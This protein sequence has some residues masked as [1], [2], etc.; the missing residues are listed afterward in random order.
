VL[1]GAALLLLAALAP[2]SLFRLLPFLEAGP[3]AT[4]R[5]QPT[6]ASPRRRT[7]RRT[8]QRRTACRRGRIPRH[9]TGRRHRRGG[10]H[11]RWRRWIG[12]VGACSVAWGRWIGWRGSGGSG[13]GGAVGLD[14]FADA[15]P[16]GRPRVRRERG[17]ERRWVGGTGADPLPWEPGGSIPRMAPHPHSA[18][19]NR[20]VADLVAGRDPFA[21]G[22]PPLSRCRRSAVPAL[23]PGVTTCVPCLARQARSARTTW[24]AMSSG[25]S[26]SAGSRP[27]T[28]S[29]GER[30]HRSGR[31]AGP[32]P[33]PAVGAPWRHRRLA[34]G[35]GGDRG[36][37]P[38]PGRPVGA[39]PTLPRRRGRGD[40][41][42]R[43]RRRAGVLARRPDATGE[44]WLPVVVRW[45][46]AGVTGHRF[47][48]APGRVPGRWSTSR[49]DRTAARHDG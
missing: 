27:R 40:G 35:P 16:G 49:R 28:T 14:G 31:P 41:L 46:W 9:R 42:G 45:G 13:S 38:G 20:R 4:S 47:E 29:T 30:H 36:R 23:A 12:G 19:N 25:L 3:S 48:P 15:L 34:G 26:S 32:L 1:G 43:R 17:L 5:R 39:E 22:P 7:D 2:W 21:H 37:R 18:I 33:L 24:G 6:G 11:R 44:Q 8:G 10:G